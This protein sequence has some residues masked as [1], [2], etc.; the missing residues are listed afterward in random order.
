MARETKI[1]KGLPT[2]QKARCEILQVKLAMESSE[3]L[4]IAY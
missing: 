4:R 1:K 3:D 2:E